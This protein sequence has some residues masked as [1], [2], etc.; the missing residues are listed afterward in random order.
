MKWVG[1][2]KASDGSAEMLHL[3]D[4]LSEAEK[5]AQ[6]NNDV[7][8]SIIQ[9][10]ILHSGFIHTKFQVKVHIHRQENEDPI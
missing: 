4:S 6:T 8:L 1:P 7:H 2:E 5:P 10:W 9:A 3:T